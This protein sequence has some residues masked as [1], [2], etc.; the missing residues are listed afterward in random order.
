MTCGHRS[1]RFTEV[2]VRPSPDPVAPP[3]VT[4]VLL[5]A[6][7]ARRFVGP[8]HKLLAVLPAS[9]DRA[10]E[11]VIERSLGRAAAAVSTGALDALVVVTGAADVSEQVERVASAAATGDRVTTVH[12]ARWADGQATSVGVGIAA[13]AALGADVV[14]IGRAD[15]PDGAAD[16]W[17]AA[18]DTARRP[19]AT[20]VCVATYDGRPRNPVALHRSVWEHLPTSG[21]QGAR[22]L[23]RLQPDLVTPVPSAGSPTDI[24]TVE[25]LD[26]W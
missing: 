17:I 18:A 4:G 8:G 15:Q 24:D 20:P 19:G 13:A 16:A 9:S 1:S 3:V 10:A 7:G 11:S 14:V 6:G 12:N 21:D 5:A 2:V 26:R 25:D 22:D 23:I